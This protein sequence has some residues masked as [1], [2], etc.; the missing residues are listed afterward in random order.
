MA[1]ARQSLTID[2]AEGGTTATLSVTVSAGSDLILIVLIH[3][4]ADGSGGIEGSTVTFGG[5]AL[6]KAG[7]A[8]N[9]TWSDAEIWYLKN[10]AVGTANVVATL[11]GADDKRISAYVLT[12]VDQ[13]TT[14]RTTQ[15]ATGSGTSSSLT[16]P[17]VAAGDYLIDAL[18]IDSTGHAMVAG[19]NQ[20]EEYDVAVN[21]A[22]DAG[23]STQAGA[24]G[25]VMS[26]SWTTSAPYSHVAIALIPASGGAVALE[27]AI[28]GQATIG[29]ALD[30]TLSLAAAIAAA[31]SV[32]SALDR[33]RALEA[34]I[35]GLGEVQ[36]PLGTT[37]ALEA[38]IAGGATIVSGLA[39]Q[40]AL[41]AVVAGQAAVVATLSIDGE[42][43]LVVSRPPR[44]DIVYR[45]F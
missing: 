10:P 3:N 20:T 4:E 25:G 34:A 37:V 14:F 11:T 36:A 35:Q 24:D 12:G 16:V 5:T 42:Q 15:T 31:G 32:A 22:C 7:N 17:S 21:A 30:R 39:A 8:D 45:L 43:V 1:I 13:V 6:T 23:S 18:T 41:D 9:P 33:G 40:R 28:Q 2:T 38:L 29:A 27:A 26:W 19:A 44:L